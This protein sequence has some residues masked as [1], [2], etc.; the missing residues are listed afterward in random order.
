M[1]FHLRRLTIIKNTTDWGF[2]LKGGENAFYSKAKNEI[3][4]I[5]AGA[6]K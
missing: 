1:I 6:G 4:I 5:T 3:F 2:G